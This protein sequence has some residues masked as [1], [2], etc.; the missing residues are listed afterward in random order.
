MY[1]FLSLIRSYF[2]ICEE[3]AKLFSFYKTNVLLS[4]FIDGYKINIYSDLKKLD[5][6]LK[7]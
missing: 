7:K 5:F 2:I 3:K 6:K 1:P 4:V